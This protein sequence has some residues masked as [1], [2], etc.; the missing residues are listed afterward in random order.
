MPN[1]ANN[2]GKWITPTRRKAIYIRDELTCV[3]CNK[4]IEDGI[5][6]TLDHLIPQDLGGGNESTNLV[7]CCK[8]CN[9]TKGSKSLKDFMT[10][11]RDSGVDTDKS[12]IEL[13]ETKEEN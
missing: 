4:G 7:T 2:G 10:W 9:S 5:I 6:F 12:N 13:F 11:L 1:I 8:S 3:Y